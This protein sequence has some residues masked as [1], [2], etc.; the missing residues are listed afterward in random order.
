LKSGESAKRGSPQ[1]RIGVQRKPTG[2]VKASTLSGTGVTGS[3][4]S[5]ACGAAELSRRSAEPFCLPG[6]H[7]IKKLGRVA[8]AAREPVAASNDRRLSCREAISANVASVLAL[9]A[10]CAHALSHLRWQVTALR[11]PWVRPSM[12]R[13]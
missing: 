7:P 2:T 5:P 12:G 6:V 13:G 1:R 3:K 9:E 4:S 11:V 8:A 10:G